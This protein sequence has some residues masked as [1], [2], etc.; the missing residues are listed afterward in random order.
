[1]S[2]VNSGLS[3][4]MKDASWAVGLVAVLFGVFIVDR[5]VPTPKAPPSKPVVETKRVEPEI[6]SKP[7]RIAVTRRMYDDMGKLLKQL[8]AG[9]QYTTISDDQLIDKDTLDKYDIVFATCS[10][11]PG[12]WFE[13][14]MGTAASRPGTFIGGKVKPE[15][16]DRIE[17]NLRGFVERG[18]TLYVSDLQYSLL[19]YAFQDYVDL[20]HANAGKGK[21]TVDAEVVEGSLKKLVGD[22]LNLI[23]EMDDWR[24][25]A[26]FEDKV[27]VLLQGKYE[28]M[29][30]QTY[31]APLLVKFPCE[32]GSVI[33]TAFHNEKQN[34]EIEQKLL[35][36]LV[37]ATVLA[38][39]E[40]KMTETLVQG[41][42]KQAGKSLLSVS[43]ESP[44]VTETYTAK[45]DKPL[46]FSLGFENS[47]A[48]MRLTVTGPDGKSQQKEGTSPL[49]I[50]IPKGTAGDWKYTITAVKTPFD[51]FPYALTIGEK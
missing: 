25:A 20:A 23:F 27:T 6:V 16:L 18:G 29:D 48:R 4:P 37:F 42:F 30:G 38:K 3:Q 15:I 45:T 26:F 13:D 9:Y 34:S 1:M 46:R 2:H 10:A 24:P 50:D 40:S 51:N 12:D 36:Y 5:N 28:A 8:G 11:W 22:R 33:F 47:G 44:S 32:A 19:R 7:L 31:E 35:K 17:Q 39:T 43:T 14:P 21:Q 49:V 41:G